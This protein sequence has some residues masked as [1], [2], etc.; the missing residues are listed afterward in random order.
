[1]PSETVAS[2]TSLITNHLQ[3]QHFERLKLVAMGGTSYF[4]QAQKQ[5]DSIIRNI[6]SFILCFYINMNSMTISVTT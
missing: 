3:I 2:T 6:P 1:M 5:I 4:C